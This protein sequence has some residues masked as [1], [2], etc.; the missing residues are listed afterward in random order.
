MA[1]IITKQ[2]QEFSVTVRIWNQKFLDLSDPGQFSRIHIRIGI[3]IKSLTFTCRYITLLE[4]HE[5]SPFIVWRRISFHIYNLQL[6]PILKVKMLS[7]NSES[8]SANGIL[9]RARICKPFR[10]LRNLFPTWRAVR[11]TGPAGYIGW[12]NRILGSINV[13]KYGLSKYL[14]GRAVWRR[15][16]ARGRDRCSWSAVQSAAV[17]GRR[18]SGAPASC[19]A[20]WSWRHTAVDTDPERRGNV[21]T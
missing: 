2:H 3:R 1:I 15:D 10:E 12:R 13:Y 4:P 16:E 18:G 14:P 8:V 7:H 5:F 11:R 20:S 9:V 6:Q 19:P 21:L 17:D